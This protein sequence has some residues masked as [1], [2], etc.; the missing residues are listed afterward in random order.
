MYFTNMEAACSICLLNVEIT[1]RSFNRNIKKNGNFICQ[2]CKVKSYIGPILSK[3][4][5]SISHRKFNSN[6][7]KQ[8]WVHNEDKKELLRKRNKS[9]KQR[10]IVSDRN[11]K[12]NS[13][14]WSNKSD[15]QKD[16]IKHKISL[17]NINRW[18]D[19]EYKSRMSMHMKYM[20][21]NDEFKLIFKSDEFKNKIKNLWYNDEYRLKQALRL[22]NQPRCS[23]IQTIL[24]SIL[25]DLNIKYYREYQDKPADIETIIGPY[26]FDCVIPREGKS[27]LLIECQGDYWHSLDKAIRNDKSKL[28]YIAN[29]FHNKYELKYLWEHEF[30]CRDKVV[31]LI[32]YWLGLTELELI[33]YNFNDVI[34][35]N[36]QAIDYKLLLAK[37]HYL[38]NAGRG[39]IAYGAYIGDK[40][41]AVCIFSPLIRQNIDID[42]Y[43][44]N[45]V[46]ELSRLCIHPNYQKKNFASWFISRCIKLLPERYKCVISYC[47]TTFNHDGAV[48][49]ACNF[50]LDKIVQPSFWYIN[51]DGW[52]MHKKTLYN[53]AKKLK[54]TASEFADKHEYSK[55]LGK[56]KLRFIYKRNEI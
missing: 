55:I 11:T 39:G 27:T 4:N 48:Y 6:A 9:Y 32:K 12:L 43:N 30:K 24:Y 36:C 47:D 54:M 33:D 13:E 38:A 8:W 3:R 14:I 42:N 20:W 40:L 44:K 49:K 52:V 2:S 22:S 21:S 28:S 5:K 26:C 16:N 50:K 56:E 15:S 34:I 41:I 1:K 25:D 46:R 10:N 45:E 53:H 23:S 19:E 7:I 31:E 37:Y 29:N 18:K 17:Y 35:K 51:K